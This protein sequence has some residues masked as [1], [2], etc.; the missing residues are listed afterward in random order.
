MWPTNSPSGEL[1]LFVENKDG[2]ELVNKVTIE[3]QCG[4]CRGLMILLTNLKGK[5]VLKTWS[6]I[7]LSIDQGRGCKHS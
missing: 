1:V 6:K 4:P 5:G 2:E 7:K 3:N